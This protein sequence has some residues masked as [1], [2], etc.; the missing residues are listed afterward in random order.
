MG[1]KAISAPYFGP[2]KTAK[3]GR[4]RPVT[5]GPRLKLGKYVRAALPSSPAGVD[6]SAAA[7]PALSNPF[8][9]L[10]LADCVIAGGYHIVAAATGNAGALFTATQTQIVQD[11]SAI[12]GYVPGDASTDDGCDEPTALNYWLKNGFANGTRPLG[13]LNVDAT[14]RAEL[15][16]ALYLFENLYLGVELPDAWI[17]PFPTG[18]GF[19][20]D[21][22]G[23]PDPNNGHCIVGVG[24]GDDGVKVDSWGLLGTVTWAALARY[25]VPS[26]YGAAYVLLTPDELAKGQT[27]APNGVDWTTLVKDFNSIGGNVPQPG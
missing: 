4:K 13:W 14:N 27:K 15:E 8:G 25:F 24:Y 2:G 21:V 5:A 7:L 20:W 1:V 17:S 18:N 23:A 22:N 10:D 3:L 16:A 11:Y 19:I 12:G 9:N 6:Y 26:V